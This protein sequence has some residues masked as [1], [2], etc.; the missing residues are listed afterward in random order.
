MVWPFKQKKEVALGELPELPEE[1]P[2]LPSFSESFPKSSFEPEIRQKKDLP[3]LPSFPNSFTGERITNEV[4]KQAVKEPRERLEYK[5]RPEKNFAREI[6]AKTFEMPSYPLIKQFTKEVSPIKVEPVYIRIDKYQES[7]ANFNDVKK[8]LI[9][10]E[11]LLREIKELKSRE[12]MQLQ[13]W[14]VEIQETKNKLDFIDRTIF[15][16]LEG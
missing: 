8:K 2:E 7:I 12:E 10:I 14:E 16:K 5:N 15:K 11:N 6:E 9:E 3:P 13:E 4:V 1:P